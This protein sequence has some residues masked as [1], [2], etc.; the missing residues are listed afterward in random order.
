MELN[1]TNYKSTTLI[2]MRLLLLTCFL[3]VVLLSG[4]AQSQNYNLTKWAKGII[5]YRDWKPYCREI[6]KITPFKIW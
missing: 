6:S 2:K 4:N 1:K 3:S 5:S